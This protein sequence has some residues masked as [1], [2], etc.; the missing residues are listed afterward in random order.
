MGGL[1]YVDVHPLL[2]WDEHVLAELDLPA[3]LQ[4]HDTLLSFG[5]QII[6]VCQRLN[7]SQERLYINFCPLRKIQYFEICRNA[8]SK[9]E[10]GT[11]ICWLC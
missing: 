3:D 1:P 11:L 7:P 6:V 4:C 2:C 9:A 8:A 10:I 5:K